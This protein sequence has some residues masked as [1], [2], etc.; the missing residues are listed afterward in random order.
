MLW[1]ISVPRILNSDAAGPGSTPRAIC[2]TTRSSVASSASTSSSTRAISLMNSRCAGSS[3]GIS[4]FTIFF[5][6]SMRYIERLKKI[7]V[8]H[9]A[10][11]AGHAGALVAEQKFG[12]SPAL[13]LFADQVLHGHADVFQEDIVDLVAAVDRDDRA[14]GDSR[15]FHI[16]QQERDAGLRLCALIG[17]H[18]AKD[19]VGMLGERSPGLVAI[20]DIVVTVTHRLGADRG[21]IRAGPWLGIALAPPVVAGQD[22][23]QEALLLRFVAKC[24][25]DRADHG[26]AERQRRQRAGARRFLFEDETL[27]NRPARTA[28]LLRPEWRYPA[29][30]VENAMPEQ[31]LLLAQIGLWIGDAHFGGIILLDERANVVAKRRIFGGKR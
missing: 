16:D 14:H 5:N 22:T 18:Q 9:R 2:A 17:P 1:K 19:P 27:G 28:I 31:H 4:A 25:D 7:D 3:S 13:V 24:V 29:L 12:V 23:R 26:D 20:D 8:A 21:E 10:A 6:R 11:D 30:L 15:R